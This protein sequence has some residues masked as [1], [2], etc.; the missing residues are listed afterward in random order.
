MSRFRPELLKRAWDQGVSR[1]LWQGCSMLL[2]AGPY[3]SVIGF[4]RDCQ[5]GF[6]VLDEKGSGVDFQNFTHWKEIPEHI[7]RLLTEF[8][9][10]GSIGFK[11]VLERGWRLWVG[12]REDKLS[13]FGWTRTETESRDFFFPIGRNS[14]LIWYTETLRDYRGL[15]LFPLILDYMV[16]TLASEGIASVYITCASYNYASR[17]GI[18]KA[19]CQMIGRGL[20]RAGSGRGVLWRSATPPASSSGNGQ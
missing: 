12:T 16:H 6:Q 9:T 1:F 11:D 2:A 17:R 4:R 8:D 19:N 13:V 20:I 15:G 14:V 7:Q 10:T 5:D 18:E 3:I